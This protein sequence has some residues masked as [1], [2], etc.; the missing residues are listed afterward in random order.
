VTPVRA[1]GLAFD[2]PV[3]GSADPWALALSG[4]AMIAIFRFKIAMIP[5]IADCSGVGIVIYLAGVIA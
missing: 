4:A 3:L 2:A 5:T 1:Y